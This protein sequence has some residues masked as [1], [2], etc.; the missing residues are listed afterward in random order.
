MAIVTGLQI[1]K[2]KKINYTP[3]FGKYNIVLPIVK[4]I[5]EEGPI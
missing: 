2:K 5:A 4:I 1:N 3:M